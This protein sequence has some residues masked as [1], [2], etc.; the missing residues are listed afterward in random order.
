MF[1]R[2]SHN[3]PRSSSSF[4]CLSYRLKSDSSSLTSEQKERLRSKLP[5]IRMDADIQPT[6]KPK[7]FAVISDATKEMDEIRARG[8]LKYNKAYSPPSNVESI[9][10]DAVK[11]NAEISGDWKEYSIADIIDTLAS[12]L[13]LYISN[14][15]LHKMKT[16]SD[17]L[18]FYSTPISNTTKYTQMARDESLPENL[19]IREH[20]VRFHPN[21]TEA[22][23][24]GITAYP[25]EGGEVITLRNKRLY[26]SFKPKKE[27]YD[28]DDQAFDWKRPDEGMP[29]DP[30]ISQKMDR[31]VD[32]K[33]KKR[34]I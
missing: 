17:I 31:Y 6:K 33:F 22:L 26:R 5:S 10:E 11:S 2:F 14:S 30:E 4:Q 9:V 25:G 20:P 7:S 29:W 21:D 28:Y 18:E 34:S 19:A 8:I 12:Q 1:T 27:W 15:D 23:H 3:V 16:A 13:G 24:G 32:K